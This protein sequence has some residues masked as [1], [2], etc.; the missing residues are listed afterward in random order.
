MRNISK[1]DAPREF[2]EWKEQNNHILDTCTFNSIST[3]AKH[4]L[5]GQLCRE[6]GFLCCYCLSRIDAS[7]D[8]MRI[9]HWE[10]QSK[11]QA[12]IFDYKNLMAACCGNEGKSRNLQHCDV[13]KGDDSLKFCPSADDVEK[14][15]KYTP[16][17]VMKST[18]DDFSLQIGTTDNPGVLNLNRKRFVNNRRDALKSFKRG[19]VKINKWGKGQLLKKIEEVQAPDA[20]G[21]IEPYCGILIY[22][23]KQSLRK[24]K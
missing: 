16:K 15:I 24:A 9:E 1:E 4:A 8:K 12:K 7:D 14:Y 21:K 10:P 18:D 5:Q 6:Q 22:F 3:K 20:E 19:L 11:N 17:G 2:K 13:R 23:L